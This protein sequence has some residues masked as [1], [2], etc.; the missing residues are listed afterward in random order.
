MN[1]LIAGS[2][3]L[4]LAAALFAATAAPCGDLAVLAPP[5]GALL[6]ASPVTL[7]GRGSEGNLEVTLNGRKVA[8]IK[9]AGRAFTGPLAL[10]EG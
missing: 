5:D 1:R 7:I 10:V 6:A 3:A 4:A 8:G 2:A 9:Q